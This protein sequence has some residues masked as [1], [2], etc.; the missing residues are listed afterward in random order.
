MVG[1]F[2][3][4]GRSITRW[5]A[6]QGAKSFVFMSRSGLSRPSARELVDDLEN[7][8][9]RCQALTSDVS[10]LTDV[11]R[12]VR[13]APSPIGGIVQASMAVK[14]INWES[15]SCDAWHHGIEAKVKGTWNLHHC[16]SSPDVEN[17]LDFF[18]LVSSVSGTIG[19]PTEPGYC[20]ANA[21]LD[22]FARYRRCNGLPGIS[23]GLG[24]VN[25][26]GYLHEHPE[27]EAVFSRRGFQGVSEDEML[28]MI[29]LAI[30]SDLSAHHER[31][32]SADPLMSAHI[33][34][35]LELQQAK[36]QAKKNGSATIE[37]L[38][39]DPRSSILAASYARDVG[40]SSSSSTQANSSFISKIPAEV[41]EAVQGGKALSDAV[42]IALS[43]KFCEIIMLPEGQLEV[44]APVVGFGL[45]SMLAAEFRGFV[46]Q[47]FNVDL[48]FMTL[49]ANTSTI[50][51]LAES[52]VKS[53]SV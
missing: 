42:G 5:M 9:A 10:N 39:R 8:G 33:L 38:F 45:D 47:K 3:G 27:M 21:F 46:F 2:G 44:D 13:S 40:Q 11:E 34:A 29:D 37:V 35:G 53:V 16:L 19:S 22:N 43:K 48:P 1:C 50:R 15:L 31:T 28:Q 24:V 6:S 52:V 12:A 17:R 51:S 30:D 41:R 20:A 23:L 32:T 49:L 25:D 4:I 36:A 14:A 26:V 7:R 18:L